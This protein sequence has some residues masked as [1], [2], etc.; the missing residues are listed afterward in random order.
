MSRRYLLTFL[1]MLLVLG[2]FTGYGRVSRH[3]LSRDH[4]V[5]QARQS[6]AISSDQPIGP[7]IS[8]ETALKFLPD[9]P[10][11]VDSRVKIR[12]DGLHIFFNERAHE[13]GNTELRVSPVALVWNGEPL[14]KSDKQAREQKSSRGSS[15]EGPPSPE[16][17]ENH[18]PRP[19]EPIVILAES[20]TFQFDEPVELSEI[21]TSLIRQIML[22]G[23]VQIR[24]ENDL[25]IL[26]SNFT[27]S[28]ASQHLFSDHPIEFQMREHRGF[29]RNV[30][31]N[32]EMQDGGVHANNPRVLGINEL[33]VR[34][35]LELH[36]Q[37]DDQPP[38]LLTCE[39]LFHYHMKSQQATM[40]GQV[41]IQRTHP[42]GMIDELNCDR[43]T[44]QFEE[45]QE[46]QP[47]SPGKLPAS[48]RGPQLAIRS[49][50]AEGDQ[51]RFVSQGNGLEALGQMMKYDL[52]RRTLNLSVSQAAQAV[53]VRFQGADLLTPTLEV[54]H[55]EQQQPI[56]VLCAGRGQL[57]YLEDPPEDQ[58]DSLMNP[59]AAG[60]TNASARADRTTPR[61]VLAEAQWRDSL[62]MEQDPEGRPGWHKITL[63]GLARLGTPV[64]RS[65]MLA[66][67]L[68]FWL[69]QPDQAS[70]KAAPTQPTTPGESPALPEGLRVHRIEAEGQV[71]VASP[72]LEG[73][74]EALH[75]D[76]AAAPPDLWRHLEPTRSEESESI[77][78]LS[79][80]DNSEATDK[81]RLQIDSRQLQL[82]VLHDESFRML[83]LAHV[84][85]QGELRATGHLPDQ[86]ESIVVSGRGAEIHNDGGERQRFR[87]LG[88]G[89][90]LAWIQNGPMRIDGIDLY[91]DRGN[92]QA[93][94]HGAG[95]LQFPI[96]TDWEGTP[97]GEAQL[98]QVSWREQMKFQGNQAHFVG[99]VRATIGDSVITCE[100][101]TVTLD[102]VISLQ[103]PDSNLKP[104][105]TEVECRD[106]VRFEMQHYEDS[107][108]MGVRYVNVSTF[109]VHHVTGEM[110]AQGPGTMEFWQ[111]R[112][113]NSPIG[114]PEA[115]M[116]RSPQT[117]TR[118]APVGWDYTRL[119]FADVLKGNI[120]R[121]QAT[122]HD[123]VNV[124][125]GPVERPL[126][127]F[128]RD[129]RPP[130]SVW[131]RCE[132]LEI[133][134]KQLP[135]TARARSE[136][137]APAWSLEIQARN[138]AEIEGEQF[139]A[140]ADLI[141]FDHQ[142]SLFV[143]RALENRHAT[144]WYYEH[145]LAERARY[146]VKLVRISPNGNILEL[147]R[148]LGASGSR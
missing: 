53:R 81:P 31:L 94:V 129:E 145:P 51:V 93:R 98:L 17:N 88:N 16:R 14:D 55:D 50:Q 48:G 23:Q 79:G 122:L 147:D 73:E 26:G 141:S 78:L 103:H 128:E 5:R 119:T 72:Q 144:F 86:K 111:R 40:L 18:E 135:E 69:E 6:L 24:G 21:R 127:S 140:R 146:D 82:K 42:D 134:L 136:K 126:V 76:F 8:H 132:L 34:E 138:N 43:L 64:H 2:V 20:A 96:N 89:E 104:Q 107:K 30:Q 44:L 7:R 70:T 52:A 58:L 11:A 33:V 143:M 9:A 112:N 99:R 67:S 66:D 45:L 87:L 1:S 133:L 19:A 125:H 32:L 142:T 22:R 106:R 114:L 137:G 105:L 80:A 108:L 115:T 85:S 92:N 91:V 113:G 97:L 63:S 15:A 37:P 29:A 12:A 57:Q 3:F 13:N 102:Q 118:E 54:Q 59:G 71:A 47:T 117:K 74:Y 130:Q 109:R 100:E 75:I 38:V 62:L 116:S 148:T 84:E 110:H 36:L 10:W 46:S 131:M 49:L 123:R 90:Q 95:S 139:R 4:L 27:F 60:L 68:I 25:Q 61:Q 41:L 83:H 121:Q 65:G 77:Q 39:D 28:R 120:H 124:L 56:R 35:H 101:L